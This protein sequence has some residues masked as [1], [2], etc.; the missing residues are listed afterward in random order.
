M[1]YTPQNISFLASN[2]V[3]VYGANEAGIHGAGAAK[4]AMK[5]GAKDREYG[6][7]GQTYGI[8]TKD[9]QIKTLLIHEI[10]V[11]VDEF[12]I[13]ATEHPQYVFLVTLIGCGLA[14]HKPQ[15]IAPLFSR[16]LGMENVVLPKEFVL[17]A[18]LLLDSKAQS[19]FKA[20]ASPFPRRN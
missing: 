8:P 19:V 10:K 2:E 5:W 6:F 7:N 1:N 9:K 4:T 15:K 3:F 17:N 13:F 11:H 14:N 12:L 20:R 16:A 18:A